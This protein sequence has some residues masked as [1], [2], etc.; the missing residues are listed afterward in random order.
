MYFSGLIYYNCD[1]MNSA[2]KWAYH[3]SCYERGNSAGDLFGMVSLRDPFQR[4]LVTNPTFGYQKVT[5]AESPGRFFHFF[6]ITKSRPGFI[7][8]KLSVFLPAFC[9]RL[10]RVVIN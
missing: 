4:L 6:L 2:L 7:D 9:R 3:L 1:V 5:A 8:F 10:R